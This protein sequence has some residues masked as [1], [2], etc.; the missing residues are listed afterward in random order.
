MWTGKE[1]YPFAGKI[2]GSLVAF[3]GQT[4][5][6]PGWLISGLRPWHIEA[7]EVCLRKADEA[8]EMSQ[9]HQ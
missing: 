8:G 2:A 7:R 6:Q 1:R 9:P 5:L 3:P 4:E